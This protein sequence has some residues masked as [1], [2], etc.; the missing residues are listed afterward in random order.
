M[1]F[2]ARSSLSKSLSF[3]TR[4]IATLAT[5]AV[6]CACVYRSKLQTQ[7][8]AL[9]KKLRQRSDHATSL[10]SQVKDMALKLTLSEEYGRRTQAMAQRLQAKLNILEQAALDMSRRLQTAEI[11]AEQQAVE[12]AMYR[13]TMTLLQEPADSPHTS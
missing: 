5:Y 12:L 11:T 8:A 3:L 7:Q 13:E 10:E 9:R 1:T 4:D 2:C 6:L